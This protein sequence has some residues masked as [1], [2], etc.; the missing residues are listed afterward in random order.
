MEGVS[1]YFIPN[2]SSGLY[3]RI[4]STEGLAYR[5]SPLPFATSTIEL[6]VCSTI[7]ASVLPLAS[8]TKSRP[9]CLSSGKCAHPQRCNRP[10]QA[11]I[12]RLLAEDRLTLSNSVP[13]LCDVVQVQV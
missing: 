9:F 2:S 5:I 1:Q 8:C 11:G 4:V 3:P 6:I 13:K 7:S 10:S 12:S